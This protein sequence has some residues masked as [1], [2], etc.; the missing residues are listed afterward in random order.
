MLAKLAY[1]NLPSESRNQIM[2]SLFLRGVV[3]E[4]KESVKFTDH[5]CRNPVKL[6]W[7]P[8]TY[9]ICYSANKCNGSEKNIDYFEGSQQ[10]LLKMEQIMQTPQ[11]D[12]EERIQRCQ[13]RPPRQQVNNHRYDARQRCQNT[14][15]C[16]KCGEIGHMKYHCSNVTP[17]QKPAVNAWWEMEDPGLR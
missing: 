9:S 11:R 14:G 4:I 15:N 12:N 3:S 8:N 5:I 1:P 10:I 13:Y 16:N 17:R 7:R 2:N 6:W